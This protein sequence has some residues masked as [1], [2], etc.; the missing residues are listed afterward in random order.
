[1]TVFNTEFEY[2]VGDTAPALEGTVFKNM[3]GATGRA[4]IR[5]PDGTVLEK[6]VD[7][8]S[9]GEGE[10][11]VEWSEED[12]NRAGRYDLEVEVTYS[13]GTKQTFAKLPA[14]ADGG[15]CSFFAREQFA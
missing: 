9:P 13:D 11:L 14:S 5:R 4:N 12:L 15:A 3:T 10:W 6:T 1:M 2:T 7:F 8:T